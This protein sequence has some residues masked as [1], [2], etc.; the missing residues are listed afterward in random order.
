MLT[1]IILLG[2]HFSENSGIGLNLGYITGKLI[3]RWRNFVSRPKIVY[4]EKCASERMWRVYMLW[5]HLWIK[6]NASQ[7]YSVRFFEMT[8]LQDSKWIEAYPEVVN[9]ENN[10]Y[11]IKYTFLDGAGGGPYEARVRSKNTYGWSEFSEVQKFANGKCITS[12]LIYSCYSK[13]SI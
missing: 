1:T 5:R 10:I 13:V 11:T 12:S 7:K 9:P 6:M 2:K 3:E 4:N 8:F